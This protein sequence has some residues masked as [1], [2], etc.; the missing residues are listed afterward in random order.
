MQKR[1]DVTAFYGARNELFQLVHAAILRAE[2]HGWKVCQRDWGGVL[3]SRRNT[4]WSV[5][6][7]NNGTVNRV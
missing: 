7:L 1:Y 5:R 4:N 6:I 3:L 2:S